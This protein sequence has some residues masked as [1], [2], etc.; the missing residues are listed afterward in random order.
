MDYTVAPI[1]FGRMNRALAEIISVD[2][3]KFHRE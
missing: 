2:A 1:R 3:E